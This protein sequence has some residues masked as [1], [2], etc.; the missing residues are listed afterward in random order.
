MFLD[1]VVL[2]VIGHIHYLEMCVLTKQYNIVL[3]MM[4]DGCAHNVSQALNFIR[5][6]VLMDQN[7]NMV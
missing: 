5:T 4:Q 2:V 1:K 7:S 6:D 3:L